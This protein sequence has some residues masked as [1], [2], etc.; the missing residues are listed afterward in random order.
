MV[1]VHSPPHGEVPFRHVGLG[2]LHGVLRAAG[3]DTVT[4][5]ISRHEEQ[6]G[7]DVYDEVILHLS[8]KVGD[9]SDG[10]DPLLLMQVLY[11]EEFDSLLPVSESILRQVDRHQEAL[12][13]SGDVYLF[14]VNIITYYFAAAMALRLRRQGKKTAVGGPSVRFDPIRALLLR[15]G[16]FEAAVVGEGEPI[17]AKLVDGLRAETLRGIPGVSF[18]SGGEMLTAKPAAAPD[19][20]ALPYPVFDRESIRDYIPILAARGC[21]AKCAYCSEPFHWTNRRRTP[22]EVLAEMDWATDYYRLENFH[23][24]DDTINEH[25]AWFHALL[26]QLIERGGRYRW[27]SFCGPVGLDEALLTKMRRSG[28]ALLKLGVQ[29]FAKDTLGRMR[30]LRDA[31]LL[32]SAIVGAERAGISMHYDMLICFPGESESDHRHNVAMIERIFAETDGVYFSLNPFYLAVG[33]E[34]HLNA[35]KYGVKVRHFDPESLPP[36]LAEMV[37]QCGPL[38]VGFSSDISRETV[39]RRVRELGEVLKRYGRD[40]LYLGQDEVPESSG[41]TQMSPVRRVGGREAPPLFYELLLPWRLEQSR[42]GWRLEEVRSAAGG[43]DG[44]VKYLFQHVGSSLTVAVRL[45]PRREDRPCF[46]HTRHFN[47][48]HDGSDASSREVEGLLRAVAAAISHN[49][50]RIARARARARRQPK[51]ESR[52]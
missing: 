1:L 51:D 19:L 42:G 32:R 21:R 50:G 22:A 41:A 9:V 36:R 48:F 31:D 7:S 49:E 15:C 13:T 38:P 17:I 4:A 43:E 46:A 37:R 23:F 45:A 2:Y 10:P 30:R 29:S 33:S 35:A 27:E 24:H 12:A 11:P 44:L 25:Q 6:A 5:D 39:L 52:R 47:L 8:S 28:C 14:T 26:D 18:L 34:T 20:G 16:A 3:Y 40:Y